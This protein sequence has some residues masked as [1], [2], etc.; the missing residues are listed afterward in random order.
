M[1]QRDVLTGIAN[2]AARARPHEPT[3]TLLSLREQG[4]D[5]FNVVS[6]SLREE[7][8]F[9]RSGRENMEDSEL[10]QF[11]GLFAWL[12]EQLRT[13]PSE[14]T[15]PE[16]CLK[17]I[18][19]LAAL[20]ESDAQLWDE[21]AKAVP[22]V[23]ELL[24]VTLTRMIKESKSAD[25]EILA[26]AYYSTG[27]TQ[28]LLADIASKNWRAVEWAVD[29]L[30]NWFPAKHHALA[31]L[32]RFDRPGLQAILE[33]E[34]DFFE[35]VAYVRHAPAAQSLQLAIANTNWTLKFWALYYSAIRAARGS[36]SYPT[37]W[38]ILLSEAAKVPNEWTRWLAVLNEY[39]GRRRFRLACPQTA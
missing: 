4:A 38:R 7:F 35:I 10:E 33:E 15:D 29:R 26:S 22:N 21:L 8:P 18:L 37:E 2:R 24:I 36:E 16:R 39:P 11:D 1:K 31:A 12:V 25:Q 27:Q 3:S 5:A 32:Y 17:N 20:L 9:L 28:M 14:A 30:R 6:R 34:D 23:P 19:A 13:F